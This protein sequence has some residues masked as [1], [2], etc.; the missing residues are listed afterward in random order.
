MT[1]VGQSRLADGDEAQPPTRAR[2]HDGNHEKGANVVIMRRVLSPP[3][4]GKIVEVGEDDGPLA[5]EALR[6]PRDA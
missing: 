2:G 4:P 5:R 6:P 3:P 1:D